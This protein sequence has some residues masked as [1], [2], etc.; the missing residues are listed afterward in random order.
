MKGGAADAVD[1]EKSLV[2]V[3]ELGGGVGYLWGKTNVGEELVGE[4][5]VGAIE[6]FAS[7]V[8]DAG[9]GCFEKSGSFNTNVFHGGRNGSIFVREASI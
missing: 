1:F 4:G 7:I 6:A 9:V 8:G 2:G 5:S 3:V